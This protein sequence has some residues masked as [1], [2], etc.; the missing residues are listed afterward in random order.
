VPTD[1][2]LVWRQQMLYRSRCTVFR[3]SEGP[4]PGTG[5]WPD[6]ITVTAVY[7]SSDPVP[8]L[9]D[10]TQNDDDAQPGLG[11][12]KRR[13]ALTEDGIH[14]PIVADVQSGDWVRDETLTDANG[15]PNPNRGTV[16][17]VMGSGRKLPSLGSRTVNAKI[18][19]AMEDE[20]AQELLT[21]KGF[22][23]P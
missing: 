16:H 9:Y 8:A 21:L 23:Y 17:R 6:E 4:D 15:D 2:K 14:F 20:H 13:S 19:Q 5:L 7:P 11:R 22:P 10:Y 18:V 3:P 1:W 12:V